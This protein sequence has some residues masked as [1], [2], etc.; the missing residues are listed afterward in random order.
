[1]LEAEV[2]NAMIKLIDINDPLPDNTYLYYCYEA[3]KTLHDS[4]D[5]V[6]FHKEDMDE[7]D[8][9]VYERNFI[10]SFVSML[11]GKEGF[12]LPGIINGEIAKSIDA[13]APLEI[14][15]KYLELK[16]RQKA[17][18]NPKS[19]CIFPDFLI[20]ES[21]SPERT[22]WTRDNQHIIIESKTNYIKDRYLF[23]L[24][25]FK[26]NLYLSFLNFDKA[27]YL[28]VQTPKSK[29]EE[30]LF[31]YEKNEKLCFLCEERFDD[32]YFFIQEKIESEPQI[33]KITKER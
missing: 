14:K 7:D 1:M 11:S 29:I 22:T 9:Q 10:I 21:H 31:E 17:N 19:C 26:I 3:M 33:Y 4:L 6:C 18:Y 13:M 30:Y 12:R 2:F 28:I 25:F 16:R 32:L 27:I 23:F 8:V 24:D 5:R 15:E 20:H